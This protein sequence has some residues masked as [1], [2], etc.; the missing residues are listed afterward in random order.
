MAGGRPPLP[1]EHLRIHGGLIKGR[2][3]GRDGEFK[4]EGDP[5]PVVSLQG[6]ALKA[7]EFLTARL[8]DIA[9]ELDSLEVVAMCEWWAEY[10]KWCD[11]EDANDYRQLVGKATAYKQFRTIAARFGLSPTDRVGLKGLG[12]TASDE[13][14]DLIAG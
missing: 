8:T 4:P 1:T 11:M 12:A 7:W 9:T 2:H 13:L 3:D 10:R 14:S 5:I 6:D